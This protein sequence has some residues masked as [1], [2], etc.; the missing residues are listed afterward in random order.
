MRDLLEG[1]L[2]ISDDQDAILIAVVTH[3]PRGVRLVIIGS[4][5]IIETSSIGYDENLRTK[6][7]VVRNGKFIW[8]KGEWVQ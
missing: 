3:A 5:K 4:L 8:R 6:Y 7:A 1:D 2:L